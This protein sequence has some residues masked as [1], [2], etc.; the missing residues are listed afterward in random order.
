MMTMH[1]VM[2]MQIKYALTF[3]VLKLTCLKDCAALAAVRA[4]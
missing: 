3:S 2:Q 1:I 4:L